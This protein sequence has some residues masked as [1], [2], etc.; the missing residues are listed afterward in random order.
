MKTDSEKVLISLTYTWLIGSNNKTYEVKDA[1]K[2][3][4]LVCCSWVVFEN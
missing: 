1:I 2:T 4:Q 3:L